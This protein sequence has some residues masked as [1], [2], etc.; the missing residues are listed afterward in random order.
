MKYL[1][2]VC[3]LEVHPAFVPNVVPGEMRIGTHGTDYW[4]CDGTKIIREMY[5]ETKDGSVVVF[6]YN[7]I[8][9]FQSAKILPKNEKC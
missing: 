6:D 9:H 2:P 5:V 7:A 4:T 3:F 1:C 8:T